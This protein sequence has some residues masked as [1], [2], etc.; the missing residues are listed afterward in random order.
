MEDNEKK[1]ESETTEVETK[2]ETETNEEKKAVKT[3]T[4]SEFNEALKKEVARKTK[5]VPTGEELK[6]YNEWKESQKTESEK[7]AEREKTYQQALSKNDELARENLALR[8]G[9]KVDDLDYVIYKVS[10]L[11]GE[12]EDNLNAYLEDNPKF[13]E[14][15]NVASE[16]AT[17]VVSKGNIPE[18]ESGVTAILKAK[19]PELF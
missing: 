9:V 3:F 2:V 15:E 18:K 10:K 4:Q 5:N 19:H 14:V 17:G 12:F 7:I 11:E 8:K 1:V 6:K 13:T 16:K